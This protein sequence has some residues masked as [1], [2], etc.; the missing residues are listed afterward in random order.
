MLFDS[1]WERNCYLISSIHEL[2]ETSLILLKCWQD[3]Y[4][5]QVTFLQKALRGDLES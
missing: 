1:I 2:T 3:L 5:K 4:M